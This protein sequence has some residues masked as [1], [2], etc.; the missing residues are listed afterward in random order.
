MCPGKNFCS[1]TIYFAPPNVILKIFTLNIQGLSQKI[2]DIFK[3]KLV[4]QIFI[5]D[6]MALYSPDFTS[7]FEEVY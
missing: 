3:K 2:S 1:T 5:P 6:K 7:T 4:V